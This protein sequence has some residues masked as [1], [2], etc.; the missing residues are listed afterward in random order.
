MTGVDDFTG[1]SY[2]FTIENMTV[3]TEDGHLL[4]SFTLATDKGRIETAEWVNSHDDGMKVERTDSNLKQNSTD[5]E[6]LFDT[7][8]KP[9]LMPTEDWLP[10][11]AIFDA[12][13]DALKEGVGR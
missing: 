3:D 4:A 5:I 10:F 2:A 9:G 7:S 11:D 13:D 1:V 12:I 6:D 8:E